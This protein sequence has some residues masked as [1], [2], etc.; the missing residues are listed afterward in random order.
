MLRAVETILIAMR[1]RCR[2]PQEV[3]R[4]L[5]VLLKDIQKAEANVTEL[6]REA[7]R[8]EITNKL[9]MVLRVLDVIEGHVETRAS[10]PAAEYGLAL[11]DFVAALGRKLDDAIEM[12][13]YATEIESLSSAATDAFLDDRPARRSA[14]RLTSPGSDNGLVLHQGQGPMDR[15]DKE[16]AKLP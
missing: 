3:E 10:M 1:R 12:V 4:D 6:S 7:A 2:R 5:Q 13:S 16:F 14:D 15:V 11:V 9:E 8:R